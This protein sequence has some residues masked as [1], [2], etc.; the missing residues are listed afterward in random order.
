MVSKM[1]ETCR[2]A[3]C[4]AGSYRLQYHIY[5]K[6]EQQQLEKYARETG[7]VLDHCTEWVSGQTETL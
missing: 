5:K 3:S 4:V 1:M 7:N 2:I 6:Y